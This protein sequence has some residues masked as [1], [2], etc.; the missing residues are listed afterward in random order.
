MPS[1]SPPPAGFATTG[2]TESRARRTAASAAARAPIG[3]ARVAVTT[4]RTVICSAECSWPAARAP[5]R[6]RAAAR[7][8]SWPLCPPRAGPADPT[9]RA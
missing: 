5:A 8:T 6:A 2:K 3:D 1:S 7:A 9:R 4:A